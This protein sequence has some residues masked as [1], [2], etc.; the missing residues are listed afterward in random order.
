MTAAI[1]PDDVSIY[2]SP[3]PQL[4]RALSGLRPVGGGTHVMLDE[5]G[6]RSTQRLVAGDIA[7]DTWLGLW[8]AE[9]KVQAEYLYGRRLST[10]MISAARAA[11]WDVSPAPQ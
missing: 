4:L 1:G 3:R 5:I 7:G 11:G 6:V 9:L 8:P 2:E 10:P